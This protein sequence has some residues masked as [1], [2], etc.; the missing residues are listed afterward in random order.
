MKATSSC[1]LWTGIGATGSDL[2]SSTTI[3]V[4][5][6]LSDKIGMGGGNVGMGEKRVN[7]NSISNPCPPTQNT[8]TM[9]LID[10]PGG[11]IGKH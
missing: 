10:T 4:L 2:H 7:P 6:F 5:F 11:I 9:E 8:G 3:I 1:S